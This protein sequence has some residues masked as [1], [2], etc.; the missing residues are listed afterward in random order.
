MQ[1]TEMYSLQVKVL[2]FIQQHLLKTSKSIR[3]LHSSDTN[4]DHK[5]RE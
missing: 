3:E 5:V 4:V 1:W 2:S